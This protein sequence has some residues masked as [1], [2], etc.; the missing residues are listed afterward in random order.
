MDVPMSNS[1]AKKYMFGGKEYQ[2]E[3]NLGWYDVS[4]VRAAVSKKAK[5]KYFTRVSKS[6]FS[7]VSCAMFSP[8][9]N[10]SKEISK[11]S[12]IRSANSQKEIERLRS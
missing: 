4:V 10:L 9:A 6:I 3:L 5:N 12:A 1:V 7:V 11:T 2:D 8:C